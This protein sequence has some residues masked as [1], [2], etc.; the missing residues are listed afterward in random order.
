[1][2][3]FT[4]KLHNGQTFDAN[5]LA[6][7]EQTSGTEGRIPMLSFISNG[8]QKVVRADSVAEVLWHPAGVYQKAG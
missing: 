3:G 1:M 6:N 5:H 7:V 8:E 4:V 2:P